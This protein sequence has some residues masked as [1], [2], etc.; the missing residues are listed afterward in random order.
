MSGA[1]WHMARHART[2]TRAGYVVVSIDYRLAPGSKFPAQL[3]DCRDAWRWMS[4]MAGEWQI[5][6]QQMALYGYSAGAHLACLVGLAIPDKDPEWVRPRA[7]I[8]GG[9]PCDFEWIDAHSKALAYFLGGSRAEH[10]DKYQAASPVHYVSAD[11]PPVLLYHGEIDTLVPLVS[12]RRLESQL[13][14]A[15]IRCELVVS[16]G[17]GHI[18]A[19]FDPEAPRRAIA[20]LDEVLPR[21]AVA[22]AEDSSGRED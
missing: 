1:R 17:R 9:A 13:Q 14:R 5:D 18:A 7:I 4:G 22:E 11:D 21:V 10:P 16:P 8:A 20:F 2:L 6:T 19:F 15:G 12:P 3:E